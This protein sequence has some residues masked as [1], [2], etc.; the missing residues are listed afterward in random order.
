VRQ[1][2]ER[3]TDAGPIDRIL[4][5]QAVKRK[6]A[7]IALEAS[8]RRDPVEL[9]RAIDVQQILAVES[10]QHIVE[11]AFGTAQ[12]LPVDADVE[13]A[14]LVADSRLQKGLR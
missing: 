13:Q 6:F 8:P 7:P 1:G 14:R 9:L 12:P 2:R 4:H 11:P 3:Q 5:T 10:V